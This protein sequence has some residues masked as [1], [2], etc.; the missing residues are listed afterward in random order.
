MF[1]NI[2]SNWLLT[3]VT[4]AA[5]YI[6]LPYSLKHIGQEQYGI[7]LIITSLT[8]YMGLLMLG[9]P[10]AS[11]RFVADSLAKKDYE[12]MNKFIGSSA[13]LFLFMGFV[14][15]VIGCGLLVFFETAYPI[16]QEMRNPARAAF[17]L[18][19]FYIAG[20]FFGELPYGIMA[21]HH[22]FVL[23]NAL[24]TITLVYRLLATVV[25][26]KV[27][28]SVASLAIVQLSSMALET[29]V[30]WT[31]IHRR[32]PKVRLDLRKFEMFT[33]R[34]IFSFSLFVLVLTVGFKLV[35]QTDSLVIGKFLDVSDVP[36]YA[37]A[38]SLIIYLIEFVIGIAS[39]VMPTATKLRALNQE[40]ELRALLLKWS[41]IAIS[42]SL[43]ASLYLAEF[44]PRFLK[45]WIG[46]AF[47]V[48]GGH[49]LRVLLLSTVVFLPVRGI[50]LP[51]LM[52]LGKLKGAVWTL[53]ATGLLNL[54]LSIL[55]AK[56]YGLIGVAWG[57][58]IPNLFY[59][60]TLLWLVCDALKCDISDYLRYVVLRAA[61]GCELTFAIV[62]MVDRY[63][64]LQGYPG[65]VAGGLLTVATF[66]IIW[67]FFVYSKDPYLDLQG[68][69]ARFVSKRLRSVDPS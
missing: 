56:Q 50:A 38:N 68:K 66:G 36:F 30:L 59:S 55:W 47:E 42:L 54:G 37:A 35:F 61:T 64:T 58:T 25:L 48:N 12:Q 27:Y 19:L 63:T 40:Q 65:L 51:I 53:L 33:L 3:V 67:L 44:G 29:T 24:Q 9:L 41:K 13:G 18:V 20:G 49:V 31:V 16:P 8:G 32:Y 60:V 4:V 2:G 7:W 39:V 34:T 23:R 6:L 26:L 57:T 69:C 43:L 14:S 52:G 15:L 62:G 21:A 5:T 10:M 17:L 45:V 28:P 46:P 1:K 22:D 11:V